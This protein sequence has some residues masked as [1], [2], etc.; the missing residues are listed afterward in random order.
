MNRLLIILAISLVSVCAKAQLDV[1]DQKKK[2]KTEV[3]DNS[4]KKQA[5]AKKVVK[6]KPRHVQTV[7]QTPRQVSSREPSV[8]WSSYSDLSDHS[9]RYKTFTYDDELTLDQ[10]ASYVSVSLAIPIGGNTDLKNSILH[11]INGALQGTEVVDNEWTL[12]YSSTETDGE[13]ITAHVGQE[14]SS[15]VKKYMLNNE[16]GSNEISVSWTI[17][18]VD[19][20]DDYVTLECAKLTGAFS[21]TEGKSCY[22]Q[23]TFRKRDG[24]AFNNSKIFDLSESNQQKIRQLINQKLRKK[25]SSSELNYSGTIAPMPYL[26]AVLTKD[27]VYF[28]YNPGEISTTNYSALYATIS[29]SDIFPFMN[30]EAKALFTDKLGSVNVDDFTYE[31][32][33]GV[34]AVEKY[35]ASKADVVILSTIKC[36]GREYKVTKIK[37]NALVGNSVIKSITIPNSIGKL[38]T[39]QFMGCTNLSNVFLPV[40]FQ[41]LPDSCFVGCTSLNNIVLP[42]TINKMGAFCFAESG[43]KFITL[44]YGIERIEEGCFYKCENLQ[45]VNLPKSLKYVGNLSFYGCKQLSEAELPIGIK[46]LS[47]HTFA[48]CTSLKKIILNEELESIE[49]NALRGCISLDS[50]ALPTSMQY[51]G[52]YA[53]EGCTALKSVTLNEKITSLGK[54]CFSGCSALADIVLPANLTK[55]GDQCFSHAQN[56]VGVTCMWMSPTGTTLGQNVFEG[57]NQESVLYIP[58]KAK[59]Y[60]KEAPQWMAFDKMKKFDIENLTIRQLPENIED[61]KEAKET[62]SSKKTQSKT[63]FWDN[64][65]DGAKDA[66]IRRRQHPNRSS[67]I[68]RNN[69]RTKK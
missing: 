30:T 31:V 56:L 28:L 15:I 12:G 62:N 20:G 27:G 26:D 36:Y 67:I 46:K 25:Y 44:N 61:K 35:N 43:L 66:Q 45:T 14:L 59:K 23:K 2:A 1:M 19:D 52:D 49:D 33:D 39:A 42:S 51:I 68:I 4:P 55:I 10:A 40:D 3:K 11:W 34:A 69:P 18:V 29:Y 38:Q 64:V 5:K 17:K 32:G 24:L 6:S 7:E 16:D 8:E 37:R 63:S 41:E 47:Q 57:I 53:L 58:P 54:Q 60:Y 21:E 48:Y 9:L 22:L 50:I 13:A 65:L